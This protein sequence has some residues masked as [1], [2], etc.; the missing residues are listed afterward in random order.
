V[1]VAF[2]LLGALHGAA[3]A[4]PVLPVAVA[5]RAAAPARVMVEASE[6]RLQLSRAAIATGPAVVQLVITGEDPHDLRLVR[7]DGHGHRVGPQR[8]IAETAPGGTAQW[9]GRL[10]HGRWRL[11]CSLPGHAAAG[12]RATLRVR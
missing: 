9:R 1:I 3:P 7:L 8:A 10:A 4:P 11:W 12:M 5:S 6:F 2:A